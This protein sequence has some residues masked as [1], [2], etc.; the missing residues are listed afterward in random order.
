MPFCCHGARTAS[1][2]SEFNTIA[3][4]LCRRFFS[5]SLPDRP[6]DPMP[7]EHL[8][9]LR[10][11]RNWILAGTALSMAVAFIISRI[12]PKIYRATTDVM[13]SESKIGPT[14][15]LPGWEYTILP[16]YVQFI[17]S[18]IVSMHAVKHFHLDEEPYRIT[19]DRFRRQFLD[20]HVPKNTRL[21]EIDVEFPDAH[22][23]ANLANYLA[24]EAADMNT[25]ISTTETLSTESFL[26]SRLDVASSR[27]READ[28]NNE[29]I[30]KQA[31]L[32]DRESE[33]KI[34]LNQKEQ[35]SKQLA[36]LRSASAQSRERDKSIEASLKTEPA[37]LKL[38]RSIVSD[39]F[40]ERAVQK[41]ALQNQGLL[42]AT[43]ETVNPTRQTLERELADAKANAAAD[44]AGLELAKATL[45]QTEGEINALLVLL[46]QLRSE[47]SNAQQELKLAREGYESA[48]HS[49]L[50]ASLTVTAKS[51]DVKQIVPAL[52][53]QRPVRPKP[54]FNTVLA[55]F[56]GFAVLC[57]V[58]LSI[59]G[60][61][62]SQSDRFLVIEQEP[63]NAHDR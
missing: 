44:E 53:P 62:R 57:G 18:D 29:A 12:S 20:V 34:L 47:V 5:T 38:K 45:V 15:P 17:E 50:N 42:S 54:L 28:R 43:E 33:L 2:N 32:E 19:A 8:R 24:Q 10:P 40:L 1:K 61:R 7:M 30:E 37:T 21:V 4:I 3:I 46:P 51:Q 55:G 26:K 35:A 58:A 49:Y 39:R 41:L 36:D 27:L 31:R 59:E 56:L 9:K 52:P 16:T 25:Q 63:V 13:I 23:A 11:H 14:S 22:L 60:I 48:T 6:M